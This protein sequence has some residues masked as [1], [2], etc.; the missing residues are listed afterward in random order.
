MKLVS[1]ATA[2]GNGGVSALNE[3]EC[4]LITIKSIKFYINIVD[5]DLT[6]CLW[7]SAYPHR[8]DRST[9]WKCSTTGKNG[10]VGIHFF[11]PGLWSRSSEKIKSEQ[12]T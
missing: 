1:V 10:A 2:D 3:L 5:N 6:Q 4:L 9:D 11:I 8:L 7:H 12:K